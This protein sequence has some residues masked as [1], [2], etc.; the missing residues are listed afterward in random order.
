MNR[1]AGTSASPNLGR[2]GRD[3]ATKRIE[4]KAASLMVVAK[5]TVSMPPQLVGTDIASP[6]YSPR[7]TGAKFV[8][9]VLTAK[10]FSRRLGAA[11]AGPAIALCDVMLCGSDGRDI[12]TPR[13]RERI[14]RLQLPDGLEAQEQ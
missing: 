11:E 1:V 12:E 10:R 7:G 13:Y 8:D 2:V 9:P 14:C 4:L 3:H 6:G 5:R